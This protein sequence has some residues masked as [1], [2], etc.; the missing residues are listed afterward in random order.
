MSSGETSVSANVGRVTFGCA[1]AAVAIVI[2][3]VIGAVFILRECSASVQGILAAFKPGVSIQD[4][5]T[6][7]LG[8][9][10]PKLELKVG[11][12]AV[13]VEVERSAETRWFGVEIGKTV[14]RVRILDNRVQYI[15]PLADL[16]FDRD[17]EFVG[18][19]AGGALLVHL[20]SPLV[21]PA[22]ISVQTDPTK[23]AVEV[24]D[25]W[26]NNVFF[27]Q[28]DGQDDARHLIRDA[29]AKQA[30]ARAFIL[31]VETDAAPRIEAL[32]QSALQASLRNGVKVKVLWRK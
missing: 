9:L 10:D 5:I 21:D 19:D 11:E 32:L 18:T 15:V 4:T 20:P 16:A 25:Q 26:L 1:A 23:I 8:E 6:L 28:P 30:G 22:M 29:A 7:A 12:R 14:T 27:W 3:C 2:V 24:D 13:D 31:E 17:W